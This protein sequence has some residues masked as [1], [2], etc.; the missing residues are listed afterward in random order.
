MAVTPLSTWSLRPTS[1]SPAT[2][3]RRHHQ[4]QQNLIVNLFV[5]YEV[6]A[7]VSKHHVRTLKALS[8]ERP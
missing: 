7:D 6:S 4:L 8:K 3:A 5:V 2:K 1:T